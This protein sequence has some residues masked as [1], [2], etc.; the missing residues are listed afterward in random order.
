MRDYITSF[1]AKTILLWKQYQL[2]ITERTR[3]EKQHQTTS[4]NW[5]N[6]FFSQIIKFALPVGFLSL[7][8]SIIIEE[9]QSHRLTILNDVLAYTLSIFV[10]LNRKIAIEHKK[11]I[12]MCVLL[13]FSIIKIITLKSVMTGSIFLLMFSL[14]AVLLFSKKMGFISIIINTLICLSLI[15]AID[16][17]YIGHYF[18]FVGKKIS[19]KW[20][21]FLLNFIFVNLVMVTIIVYI[22]EGFEKTIEKTEQL[23]SKLQL[24]IFEKTKNEKRLREALTYYKSLFFFNPLPIFIYDYATLDI[25]YVNKTALLDYGYS[26]TEFL[27][28]KINELL[29]CDVN[30]F[31]E[32]IGQNFAKQKSEHFQK[33]G[34]KMNVEVYSSGITFKDSSARLAIVRDI[35]DEV[36]FLEALEEK[37]KRFREIAHLQSHVIRSPLTKILGITKLMQLEKAESEDLEQYIK[38]IISSAEE[39]DGVVKGIIDKTHE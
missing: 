32:N 7:I 23:Y 16:P 30:Y 3:S 14:F 25:K 37:N 28:M 5:R 17:P 12:G 15:I 39:L 22:V 6:K 33:N 19:S 35:T 24:E 8:A 38:Y 1:N 20:I 29:R 9:F 27:G 26:K 11:R 13:A 4:Q 10:I 36:E 2:F 21:L 31:K 18:E 34:K